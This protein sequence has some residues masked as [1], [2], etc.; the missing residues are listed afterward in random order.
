M[1]QFC[2][3]CG[4]PLLGSKNCSCPQ[5]LRSALDAFQMSTSA[6]EGAA[7]AARGPDF[8][9]QSTLDRGILAAARSLPTDYEWRAE[10]ARLASAV[11]KEIELNLLATLQ[12]Q[13]VAWRDIFE[14]QDRLAGEA[15]AAAAKLLHLEATRVDSLLATAKSALETIHP[16][17]L[18][19]FREAMARDL[20][21]TRFLLVNDSAISAVAAAV[22]EASGNA[23]R[24]ITEGV[25]AFRRARDLFPRDQDFTLD[26]I[27][28]QAS[29]LRDSWRVGLQGSGRSFDDLVRILSEAA[30]VL[31]TSQIDTKS[32]ALM[33]DGHAIDRYELQQFLTADTDL[34]GFSIEA[35]AEAVAK[36]LEPRKKARYVVVLI[37]AIYQVLIPLLV[38]IAAT[39][40]ERSWY[41]DATERKAAARAAKEAVELRTSQ[42]VENGVPPYLLAGYRLVTVGALSV[43]AKPTRNSRQLGSLH[44]GDVVLLVDTSKRSW[45]LVEW[46]PEGDEARIR[47]WVF[48]RYL[49]RLRLPSSSAA[50]R[51]EPSPASKEQ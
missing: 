47:G 2:L 19:A 38:N 37:F 27:E 7:K 36:Q 43:R 13:A 5:A 41:E 25:D 1:M 46:A 12:P 3:H 34:R 18:D 50:S 9:G 26:T 29:A 33:I 14:V 42:A 16:P 30:S 8:E 44:L 35:L 40:I 51:S 21:A 17:A 39:K 23:W 49:M 11:P 15:A 10:L 4:K 22:N 45:T 32:S 28:S 24:Q 31:H 48:S 20:Q 6:L